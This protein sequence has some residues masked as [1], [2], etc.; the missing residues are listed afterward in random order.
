MD[1]GD[2]TV[3]RPGRAS[4]EGLLAAVPR[5]AVDE[6]VAACRVTEPRIAETGVAGHGA[7]AHGIDEPQVAGREVAAHGVAERLD[8]Q[9]LDE[10][11]S[12]YATACLT[13]A[14]CL[15]PDDTAEDITHELFALL[16]P[17]GGRDPFWEPPASSDILRARE[18]LGPDVLRE[19]FYR[20]A[21]PVT[22]G[23]TPGAW[24][25]ERRLAAIDG[26]EFDLPESAANAAEFGCSDAQ[27]GLPARPR[28]PG[29]GRR[30]VRITCLHRR[31]SR[32]VRK[33][34]DHGGHAA[35]FGLPRHAADGRSWFLRIR[36]VHRCRPD[37]S[38]AGLAGTGRPGPPAADVLSD[39]TYLSAL[40][41]PRLPGHER[42]APLRAV[43]SGAKPDP[44]AAH[45]VRVVAYD[46]DGAER[47]RLVT[48][49]TDPHAA[50]TGGLAAA[51]D[52][53][54]EAEAANR[55][56]RTVARS[57]VPALVHQEIW[58]GLLVRYAVGSR[59]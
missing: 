1:A 35:G 18:R 50:T 14:L 34:G 53:R 4:L 21:G 13:M 2:F 6:A 36:G 45:V 42:G 22:T 44:V 24:L 37:G 47:D 17:S 38:G 29:G 11:L 31:R 7:A 46:A 51:H 5:S 59:G 9:R 26:F 39:G 52:L 55:R 56:A 43:R 20:V 28:A 25:R 41:D 16:D 40:V 32:S 48:D 19:T 54:R 49:L 12:P 30:G 8:Q 23:D 27:A 57:T 33:H 15:F 10:R 3:A 58:A